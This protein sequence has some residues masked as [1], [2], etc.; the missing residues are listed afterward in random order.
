[1]LCAYDKTTGATISEFE[2]PSM[3]GTHPMTY[4]INGRQYL[5]LA[6]GAANEPAELVALTLP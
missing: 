5:V 3:G 1:M 4:I 2:L 6:V